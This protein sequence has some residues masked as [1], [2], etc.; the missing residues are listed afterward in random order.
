M[1]RF[2]QRYSKHL[3]QR[4]VNVALILGTQQA[5][6]DK[7]IVVSPG[8]LQWQAM[9]DGVVVRSG[10][11]SAGQRYCPDIHRACRTPSGTYRVIGKGGA[12]CR[13]SRYPVG[14]GGAP[15]PYCMFFSKNYAIHGSYEM[16]H[17]NASH[18]CVRVAPS[19]AK[20]L[21]SNF[22]NIGTKVVIKPY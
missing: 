21:S 2:M 22:A 11:V 19:D 18:G 16:P 8:K 12:T 14:R 9:D 17:R 4:I 10:R 6:A 5:F 3:L 1:G 15:M 20:W 7:E 13:S